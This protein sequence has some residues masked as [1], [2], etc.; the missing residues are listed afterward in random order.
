MIALHKTT[1]LDAVQPLDSCANAGTDGIFIPLFLLPEGPIVPVPCNR[2]STNL[3]IPL[4][5]PLGPLKL[6]I[7]QETL[8]EHRSWMLGGGKI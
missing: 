7:N 2:Q 4:F 8:K 6:G 1:P 5:S 3:P